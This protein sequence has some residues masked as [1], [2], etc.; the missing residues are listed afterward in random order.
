MQTPG[1]LR[2]DSLRKGA[3]LRSLILL[4]RRRLRHCRIDGNSMH[5]T[6][7]QGDVVVYL[8][9]RKNRNFLKRGKV[10]IAHHPLKVN[11]FIVKRVHGIS[12]TCVDLRG[13]NEIASQDSRHFGL[14]N[15][16]QLCGIAKYVVRF[17][18]NERPFILFHKILVE[19]F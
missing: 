1:L 4:L 5:P 8:P 3:I 9:I 18:P 19:V 2:A 17:S 12:E 14:V 6:L 11:K 15:N 7:S 10:V 16:D 13:D